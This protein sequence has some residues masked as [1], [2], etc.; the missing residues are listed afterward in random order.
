MSYIGGSPTQRRYDLAEMLAKQF[1]NG[2]IIDFIFL[3]FLIIK[4]IFNFKISSLPVPM[5][6]GQVGVVEVNYIEFIYISM[7][8]LIVFPLAYALA[9]V[10]VILALRL[11]IGSK[12][13]LVTVVRLVI[14]SF[15]PWKK[16]GL[17]D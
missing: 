13:L 14:K 11:L 3:L 9:C 7:L 17:G 8:F 15:W 2:I 4:Y 1:N 6:A 10:S 5:L 16:G 12:G